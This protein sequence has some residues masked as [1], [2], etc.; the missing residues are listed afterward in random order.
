MKDKGVIGAKLGI[1]VMAEQW[2]PLPVPSSAKTP[3]K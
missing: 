3:S 2:Q 1:Q